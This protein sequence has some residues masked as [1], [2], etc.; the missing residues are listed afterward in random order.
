VTIH[1]PSTVSRIGQ[2]VPSW[3]GSMDVS[4]WNRRRH[5]A[6]GHALTRRA[7][8]LALDNAVAFVLAGHDFE[9]EA[10]SPAGEP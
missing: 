10:G 6:V 4:R 1:G 7:R 3:T 8:T 5:V 2:P 9:P